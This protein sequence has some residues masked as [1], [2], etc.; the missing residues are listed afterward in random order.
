MVFSPDGRFLA[1]AGGSDRVILYDMHTGTRRILTSVG[2][3]Q[4]YQYQMSCYSLV[5]S[6]DSR[7][8]ING[9]SED[10]NQ[11]G[12]LNFWDTRT[13][14][15]LSTFAYGQTTSRDIAY[16]PNGRLLAGGTKGG[17]VVVWDARTGRLLGRFPSRSTAVV[18]LAFSPDSRKLAVGGVVP[19]AVLGVWSVRTHKPLWTTAIPRPE[20][21]VPSLAFSPDGKTLASGGQY[22]TIYLRD[23]GTGHL[24][25]RLIDPPPPSSHFAADDASRVISYSRDGKF[26]AGGGPFRVDVW[27][28]KTGKIYRRLNQA[29]QPFAFTPDSRFIATASIDF[30]PHGKPVL[31]RRGN[32]LLW[33]LK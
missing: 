1:T 23:A 22:N 33:P 31:H 16:S 20:G 13:G 29:A 2:V 32:V 12:P 19:R 15:H 4:F 25:Q 21:E 30:G 3:N 9:G 5:F 28:A 8:L 27:S 26:L 17:N 7:I 6:S 24:R 18:S 14:K 10:P 11:Y